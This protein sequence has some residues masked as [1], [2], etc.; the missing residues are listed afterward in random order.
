MGPPVGRD[1]SPEEGE[2]VGEEASKIVG[3][4]V[5]NTLGD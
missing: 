3:P 4:S 2:L 1:V 5:D